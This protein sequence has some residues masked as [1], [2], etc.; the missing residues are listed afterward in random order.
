[1]KTRMIFLFFFAF[2]FMSC[3]LA[4]SDHFPPSKIALGR[5][6]HVLAGVNVYDD[7]IQS[8]LKRLESRARSIPTPIQITLAEAASV[9]TIGT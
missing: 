4:S 9:R 6:E 2:V 5:P 3:Q 1:M 7:K 8:V